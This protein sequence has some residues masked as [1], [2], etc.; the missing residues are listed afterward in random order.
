MVIGKLYS[1]YC[2]I[3]YSS[4]A[5]LFREYS[6]YGFA[7]GVLSVIMYDDSGFW[8][9]DADEIN[10]NCRQ[11]SPK[12]ATSFFR[13]SGTKA[14]KSAAT[15]KYFC[16]P[17]FSM[18]SSLVLI[19]F[20]LS[21]RISQSIWYMF[22]PLN[23]VFRLPRLSR[24]NSHPFWTASREIALEIVPVPP[25]NNAFIIHLRLQEHINKDWRY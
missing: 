16:P 24:Y 8:Y 4:Q 12:T 20:S 25:I 22:F 21:L 10:I 6:Q 2:W 11:R 19:S 17:S 1:R 3:R 14:I 7:R 5:I 9:A 18:F 15:S 13:F 23:S